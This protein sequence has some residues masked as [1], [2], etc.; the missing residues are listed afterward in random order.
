MCPSGAVDADRMEKMYLKLT[1]WG[2][3][4]KIGQSVN[5]RYFNFAGT[6]EVRKEDLQHLLDDK[7][8]PTI[9]VI[10]TQ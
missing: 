10:K 4:L 7:K 3:D 8:A 6:D 9:N 1:D 2:F 5:S